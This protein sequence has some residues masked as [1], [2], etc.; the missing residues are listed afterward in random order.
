MN[1][2]TPSLKSFGTAYL[3]NLKTM[4]MLETRTDANMCER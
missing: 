4:A 2:M 1:L 3:T